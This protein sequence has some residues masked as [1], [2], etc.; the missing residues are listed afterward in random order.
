MTEIH[1]S[2]RPRFAKLHDVFAH[3]FAE[4]LEHGAACAVVVDG[5]VMVNLWGGFADKA[6]RK[7]WQA[8][9]L[10]NVWSVTKAIMALAMAQQVEKGKL[11]YDDP[12]ARHWPEFA[13]N[14]KAAIT[15]EQVMSH[16]SGVDGAAPPVDVAGLCDWGFYTGA[17]AAMKPNWEPGTRCA[18]HALSYGHLTGEVLRRVTGQS[19]GHYIRDHIAK[20]LGVEF[21]VGLPEFEDN[22]SVE[23]IEGP[24]C[25][26]WITTV[27]QSPCPN[28]CTNPRPDHDSPNHRMWRAAEIPG[29]NGHTNALALATIIGDVA[30][31]NSKLLSSEARTLATRERYRGPDS[32]FGLDVVWSAGFS[33]VSPDYGTRASK[34]TFG[35]GGWGG[36]LAF[37]DPD[38]CLGFA[39]VTNHM[40]GFPDGDMR[41]RRL[42]EA[43]YDAL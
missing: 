25:Y 20:P 36:S 4:G 42:I 14:G 13:A 22:R 12:L 26:D 39:Y 10:A 21:Y 3:N 19:V 30:G 41:R 33:L 16:R 24:G 17:L 5:E 29:G 27:L 7:P 6:H 34:H 31:D 1:G 40:C 28:G 18:Y 38:K 11:R 15:L 9:S 35:H 37:G 2:T 43:V 32:A 23:M 8:E